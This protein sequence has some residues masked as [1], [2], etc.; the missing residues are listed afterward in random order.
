MFIIQTAGFVAENLC[1]LVHLKQMFPYIQ[2]IFFKGKTIPSI[3][4][5]LALIRDH[6]MHMPSTETGG[7]WLN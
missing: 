3:S 1:N 6:A 4:L 2:L 5:P 7:A